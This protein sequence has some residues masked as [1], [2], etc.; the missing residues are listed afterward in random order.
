VLPGGGPARDG[1]GG[2]VVVPAVP[3]DVLP[4]QPVVDA[5]GGGPLGQGR[6]AR[7]EVVQPTAAHHVA[8]VPPRQGSQVGANRQR[9]PPVLGP[10]AVDGL[11][12]RPLGGGQ[13]DGP[14]GRT[15]RRRRR[16]RDRRPRSGGRARRRPAAA[17]K[18]GGDKRRDRRE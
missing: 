2:R 10:K 3:L 18:P 4:D 8:I 13:L 12:Q 17:G 11:D 15:R 5:R 9:L 1:L 16:Q 7:T 6:P 14:L